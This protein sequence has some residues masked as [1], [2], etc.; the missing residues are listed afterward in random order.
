MAELVSHVGVYGEEPPLS[1]EYTPQ[2]E[3]V[4][5]NSDEFSQN[6]HNFPCIRTDVNYIIFTIFK[7]EFRGTDY[8][9]G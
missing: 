6:L 9:L 4:P 2:T 5:A 7:I 1:L 3:T 8:M